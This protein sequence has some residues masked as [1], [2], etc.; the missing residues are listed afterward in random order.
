MD[1]W[2]FYRWT[3]NSTVSV[4]N[5]PFLNWAEIK[6]VFQQQ[7]T[8]TKQNKETKI[9][10]KRYRVRQKFCKNGAQK[11]TG[12]FLCTVIQLVTKI[13]LN[14]SN[15][16]NRVF[17]LNFKIQYYLSHRWVKTLTIPGS[18]SFYF[19]RKCFCKCYLAPFLLVLFG[20][21]FLPVLFPFCFVEINQVSPKEEF[22]QF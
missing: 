4:Y 12:K 13:P 19:V 1:R 9:L 21:V 14:F 7:T 8:N 10:V 18:V 20:S 5:V 3:L 2:I 17:I 15:E 16:F 6:S 11:I 22:F